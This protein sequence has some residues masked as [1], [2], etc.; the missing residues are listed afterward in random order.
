MIHVEKHRII[1]Y[2]GDGEKFIY[3]RYD[4][5]FRREHNLQ[6]KTNVVVIAGNSD[7]AMSNKT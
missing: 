1:F 3:P 6:N 7:N 2:I 4:N 5:I